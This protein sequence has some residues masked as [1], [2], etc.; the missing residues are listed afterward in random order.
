MKVFG[1]D[2]KV[3]KQAVSAKTEDGFSRGRK[4]PKII[5]I[6]ESFKDSSRKDIQKWRQALL[7]ARHP[8]NPKTTLLHDLIDDLMTDGHLQSQIQMRKSSTLNTDFRVINRRTGEENEEITFTIQQQWFYNFLEVCIDTILRGYSVIEFEEFN[9][10]K[11]K[12]NLIP[13]RNIAPTKHR[14]Y[15]D[16]TKDQYIDYTLP[17]FTEWVL[18]IGDKSDLGVLNNIVPNLIWKRNVMQ[19]WAEFC[20]KFGM[21]LI[22][23]TTNT[24]DTRVVDSVH[25]ML[26]SIGEAGVGTFPQGTEIKYQEANRTDAY[27]VYQKF[28]QSNADEISKQLVGSTMLSDQGSNRS[29]T[30]VHE[31]SLDFRIA[32]A[33]KRMIQFIVN[34]LLFPM[35]KRHGYNI[36]DDDIFE[37]KMIEQEVD[38]P[39]LWNI[40]SGLI[41]K[42][43]FVDQEWISKT[44]NIPIESKKKISTKT[45]NVASTY[46]PM[47]IGTSEERYPFTC[48]CGEH[49]VA[50]AQPSK[51]QIQK[52]SDQLAKYIFEGKDTLGIEGQIISEE[53]NLMLSALRDNF[54]TFNDYEG[55]DHL[56]LQMMEYNLFEFSAS[57]TESR[58]ASIK[59][60]LIDY[61]TKEI[62]DFASF[63]VECDKVMDKYNKHWLETEYNLSI[64]VGQNSAQYIRFM[65]EKN[66]VTSFVK[67]QTAG[68]S[69]VRPQHQILNGKIFSLDD[70]EAMELYPPNGYGCRC[71]MIQYLGD[72]KGKVTRGI[73]AKNS[74]Y[75][76]DPKYKNS[77][78]EINRGDLK[79]VFTKKQF[80]SDIKGLPEKINKMTFDKYLDFDGNQ[81]LKKWEDFKDDLK[82]ILLDKTI[83]SD[84]VNELFKPLENSKKKMGFEDYI[85]RKMV[86]DKSVFGKHTKGKYVSDEE[87][88]HLLFP[89]IEDILKNPSEVWLSAHDKKGFQTNYIKHY[90]DMSILVSTTLN[91]EMKGIQIETWFKI[92]YDKPLE[93]RKG[94]L[95]HRN[96]KKTKK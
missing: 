22:T 3:K 87:Q 13:R 12:F 78:F 16:T 34:D 81:I 53:A 7:L 10:D 30:E 84:N 83:T 47:A 44:F 40:T 72:P 42:G 59:E 41:D 95:I 65:A 4:N 39:Q 88:R 63:R 69:N 51:E 11:I 74:I 25:E 31:R 49:V 76:N 85:G 38:L 93:R 46:F 50:V 57:K 52:F 20:E 32:Q 28:M 62:R 19:A 24:T 80:Y 94:I 61:E 1:Y 90:K 96:K 55:D 35:L 26:L 73:E 8:E 60:L 36:G 89:H 29:Q 33:D 2:I 71:E 79:Q 64:A 21:P 54:K 67:Y 68:D 43:Y 5:Q 86:L 15:P 9:S 14:L 6:V 70:K 92:D 58:L 56:A 23:A 45:P 82:P 17:Q 75:A 37:F 66:T 77:Q 27:N 91:E 48:D 18:P